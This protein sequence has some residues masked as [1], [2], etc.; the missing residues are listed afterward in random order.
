MSNSSTTNYQFFGN[1][2]EITIKGAKG[3]KV[4]ILFQGQHMT[5]VIP[6]LVYKLNLCISNTPFSITLYI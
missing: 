5:R 4:K 6:T 1:S 3:A 2:S